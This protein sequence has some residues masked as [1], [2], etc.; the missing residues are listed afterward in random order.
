MWFSLKELAFSE[1]GKSKNSLEFL[2]VRN[3]K[4]SNNLLVFQYVSKVFINK[5]QIHHN[6][7][8]KKDFKKIGQEL[9]SYENK[10]EKI[11]RKSRDIL[12][13]SK[14]IIYSVHRNELQKAGSLVQQIKTNLK[15]L[16]KIAKTNIRLLFSGSYKIAEQEAVEA[17]AYYSI[18]KNR[19]LPTKTDLG[20]DAEHYLLGIC[21][22]TGELVRNAVNSVTKGDFKTPLKI[23]DFVHDLYHEMQMFDFRNSELRRKVDSIK[24]DLKKLEDLALQ[25]KLKE[26]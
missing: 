20:V 5:I 3:L 25:L 21:D 17:L 14:Q 16:K 23:K 24:Y 26:K 19:K 11:V 22:L 4:I 13:L 8:N 6:M 7:L 15:V 10:R 9:I 2:G 18:I 1:F 12:K